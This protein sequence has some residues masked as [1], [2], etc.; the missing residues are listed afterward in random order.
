M[1]FEEL[2]ENMTPEMHT[3]MRQAVELGKWPD[4]RVLSDEERE[5]CLQAVIAYDH[6]NLDPAQRVGYVGERKNCSDDGPD[7]KKSMRLGPGGVE[8]FEG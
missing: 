8:I 3:A 4:G 6:Q 7:E 2:L 5:T 1:T